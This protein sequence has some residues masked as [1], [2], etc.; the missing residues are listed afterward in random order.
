MNVPR[1]AIANRS[2]VD[3]YVP[4]ATIAEYAKHGPAREQ[5]AKQ[6]DAARTTIEAASELP[7]I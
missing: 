2:T 5:L 1:L 7:E 3:R 6:A 4:G